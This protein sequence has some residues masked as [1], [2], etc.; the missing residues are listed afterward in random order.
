MAT[1]ITGAS[2]DPILTRLNGVDNYHPLDADTFSDWSIEAGDLVTVSRNGVNYKSPVHTSTMTWKG[3]TPQ[4]QIRSSGKESRDAVSIASR[5]KYGKGS[6][7][8]LN[9]QQAYRDITTSYNNMKAGLILASSAASLYVEDMYNQMK[10]GLDLTSSSASLYVENRYN[11]MKAGLDLT[12]SSASLYVEDRYN[13]MKSGLDL[14]SS[15]AALYVDSKYNQM[16]AGLDVT[17]SSATLYAQSRTTRAA[18]VARINAD[19]E[20]EALIEADKVSITGSTT[21]NSVFKVEDDGIVVKK[22]SVFQGNMLLQTAG[23]KL[24]IGSSASLEFL[25]TT[26]YSIDNTSIGTT[27]KDASVSQDGKTLTLTRYNGNT[28]TFNKAATPTLSGSWS[29]GT[30]TVTSVPAAV[31]NYT[32]GFGGSYGDHNIEME[33]VGNGSMS[34]SSIASAV[35]IPIKVNSLNSGQTAPTS[36]YTKTLT[37]SYSGLVQSKTVNPSVSAQ[38]ITPDSGKIGL[39]SVTVTAAVKQAKT[40]S[41]STSQNVVVTP[42]SGYYGLSQVT[43]NKINVQ[44]KV[45]SPSLSAQVILPDSGYSYLTSVTVNS[46]QSIYNEAYAAGSQAAW[47]KWVDSPKSTNYGVTDAV[48][49]YMTGVWREADGTQHEWDTSW[50]PIPSSSHSITITTDN[51]GHSD[52]P[53]SSYVEI[54]STT[55]F[56][57]NRW[58]CFTV[59]C[60]GTSKKYKIHLTQ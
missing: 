34:K 45:V 19:G 59:N 25:G 8:M 28:V 50:G 53:G 32:I 7:A 37:M 48:G 9:S 22:S 12:S 52:D 57:R 21:I 47:F 39:S 56:I 13:Q 36:R 49:K 38:T 23:S 41:A 26:A 60:G 3:T 31:S 1:R 54:W 58:Y 55:N 43:V 42:D 2:L 30:I 10:S 35:D 40:V 33:I 29:G 16:K 14:T 17:M 24:K 18:I 5:K 20:G 11:Q 6:G 4:V 44:A 15:S 46:A 51:V 27:I